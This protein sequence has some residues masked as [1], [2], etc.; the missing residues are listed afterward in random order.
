LSP[1]GTRLETLEPRRLLSAGDLDPTFGSGGMSVIAFG[2]AQFPQLAVGAV[3]SADAIAV[4]GGGSIVV[5]DA[6][7]STSDDLLLAKV[8]ANGQLDPSFGDDGRVVVSAFGQPDSVLVQPDGKIL[9][10]GYAS[11][12]VVARFNSDG[13]LDPAFGAGNGIVSVEP[14]GATT[15]DMYQAANLTLT[16]AGGILLTVNENT[17]FG[18]CYID[19]LL[20][21]GTLDTSFGGSG[22]VQ[23]A[24]LGPGSNP[25]LIDGPNGRI[26][27]SIY[28]QNEPL[29]ETPPQTLIAAY[30]ANG[31]IEP[32]FKFS[33][34]GKF[35][36][37]GPSLQPA[38]LALDTAGN[39]LVATNSTMGTK[40]APLR[41]GP[42]GNLIQ[43]LATF[44]LDPNNPGGVSS[45]EVASDGQLVVGGDFGSVS[46]GALSTADFPYLARYNANGSLDKTFAGSGYEFV[47][48]A[49]FALQPD[50]R[51]LTAGAPSAGMDLIVSRYE[52][53]GSSPASAGVLSAAVASV[54]P[55]GLQGGSRPTGHVTVTLTNG[56]A[57]KIS[58]PVTVQLLFS[59]DAG[60]AAGTTINAAAFTASDIKWTAVTRQASLARGQSDAIEVSPSDLPR[61]ASN[62]YLL[63]AKITGPGGV[64]ITS[65]A[66]NPLRIAARYADLQVSP[67]N[68]GDP[69]L[70]AGASDYGGVELF[71]DGDVAISGTAAIT[72]SLTPQSGGAAIAAGADQL[73]LNMPPG[74]DELYNLHFI[75]PRGLPAGSYQLTASFDGKSLGIG[76]VGPFDAGNFASKSPLSSAGS[77]V[78]SETLAAAL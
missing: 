64:Q 7:T 62:D 55:V 38:A 36:A 27:L 28:P 67:G 61:I 17:F 77:V 68:Q 66:P 25:S 23:A 59:P 26:V 76:P 47:P 24:T 6:S 71:N 56:T 11:G 43:R 53:A 39:V 40:L 16:S 33:L 44:S 18:A 37:F 14:A 15:A 1:A 10:A 51:I 2:H 60:D 30:S 41:L 65:A 13:T 34:T 72:L 5:G 19:Q 29:A 73:H 21:D 35:T 69:T 78:G 22:S 50:G 32:K 42:D 3:I 46:D 57:K 70:R 75:V 48:S 74:S 4:A 45:A 58:G 12:P 31:A 52:S 54:L 20:P 63:L 49:I 9:V 8:D